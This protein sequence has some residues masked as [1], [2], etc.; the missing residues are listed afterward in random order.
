MGNFKRWLLCAFLFLICFIILR[1]LSGI[2][3]IEG[4]GSRGHS[5]GG[6]FGHGKKG[7]N[8]YYGGRR[9]GYG[10]VTLGVTPLY[11]YDNYYYYQ[12]PY[13]Y[14]YIPFYGYF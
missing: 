14:S 5:G 8:S 11:I 7:G 10:G 12:Y 3:I 4:H 1:L 2:T 9:L 13:W 6:H